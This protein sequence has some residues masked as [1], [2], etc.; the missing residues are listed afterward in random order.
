MCWAFPAGTNFGIIAV[1]PVTKESFFW[2]KF[3]IS[4]LKNYASCHMHWFRDNWKHS[5]AGLGVAST[6]VRRIGQASVK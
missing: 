4:F 5:R 6:F 1:T 2:K 3:T